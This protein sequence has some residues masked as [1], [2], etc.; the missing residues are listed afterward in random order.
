MLMPPISAYILIMPRC[1]A[2]LALL[3]ACLFA[4]TPTASSFAEEASLG[5]T[6]LICSGT[7]AKDQSTTSYGSVLR[8]GQIGIVNSERRINF[9]DSVSVRLTS[10]GGEARIPRRLVG[11]Y[12][13]D[14]NGWYPLVDVQQSADEIIG[15]VRIHSMYKPRFRLDRITGLMTMNGTLGDFSGQC[16]A[17]DPEKVERKF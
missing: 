13:E 12:H 2:R 1:I 8:S 6:S 17:Y 5:S 16:Q 9:D 4:L 3:T 10:S 14:H 15:K 11:A 7:A